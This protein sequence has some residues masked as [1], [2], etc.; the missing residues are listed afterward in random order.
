M[1]D[2]VEV[3]ASKGY[4][5]RTFRQ[6]GMNHGAMEQGA[7]SSALP[8]EIQHINSVVQEGLKRIYAEKV[9]PMEQMYG[10]ERFHDVRHHSRRS[11]AASLPRST[12]PLPAPRRA[13]GNTK[14][15]RRCSR[16]PSSRR[17]LPCC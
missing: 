7:T 8:P 2:S 6:P 3:Q 12:P 13:R 14:R 16:T 10:F 4:E 15:L 11:A 1:D 9:R 5:A 17:S